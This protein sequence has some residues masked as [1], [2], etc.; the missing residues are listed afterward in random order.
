MNDFRRLQKYDRDS[1]YTNEVNH[2]NVFLFVCHCA[3]NDKL[4]K[5]ILLEIELVYVALKWKKCSSNQLKLQ[6]YKKVY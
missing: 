5:C 4:P 2:Q 3:L 1:V 6:I